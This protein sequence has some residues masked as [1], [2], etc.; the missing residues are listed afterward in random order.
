MKEVRKGWRPQ[1][2]DLVSGQAMGKQAYDVHRTE[3]LTPLFIP[4]GVLI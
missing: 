3:L 1:A 4:F 2:I